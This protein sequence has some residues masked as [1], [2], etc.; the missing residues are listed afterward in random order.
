MLI[1]QTSKY[2]LFPLAL[3]LILCG[4]LRGQADLAILHTLRDT[5]LAAD[6]FPYT[7]SNYLTSSQIIK[8]LVMVKSA[9]PWAPGTVPEIN[10]VIPLRLPN[11]YL[12]QLR[13]AYLGNFLARPEVEATQLYR[14]PLV[15]S[16]VPRHDLTINNIH[17]V[18]AGNPFLNGQNLVLSIKEDRFDPDDIDFKGRQSGSPP[19]DIPI[20][21]HA[22]N[23]ATMAAGGGN[24]AVN[25]KGVAW[26][27]TLLSTPFGD[28]I[29]EP[30]DYYQ[31]LKVSVQNH[32][33]GVGV[34]NFYGLDAAAYDQSVVDKPELVHVFSAGNLGE[35]AS[36]DGPYAGLP[37][38]ANISGSFKMAKNVLVVGAQD[39]TAATALRSS[40][41]PAYDGR[42]KPDLVAYGQD[43][44][45][46][47]AALVSGSAILLQDAWIKKHGDQAS[48]AMIKALLINSADEINQEGPDYKG[49]YGALNLERALKQ[50]K[51]SRCW[52]T[53]LGGTENIWRQE[54]EVTPGCTIW[55]TTLCWID[56]AALPFSHKALVHDLDITIRPAEYPDSLIYY[57][58]IL[59]SAADVQLLSA[60]ARRGP[61]T[62]NNV[63]KITMVNPVPGKYI[64]QVSKRNFNK[65][66]QAFAVV[67]YA[68]KKTNFRWLNPVQG[69]TMTGEEPVRLA[70]ESQLN[71]SGTLE[72]NQNGTWI[73]IE[74]LKEVLGG[75]H[76]WR[77]PSEYSG[78]VRFRMRSEEN[79]FLSDSIFIHPGVNVR[80]GLRCNSLNLVYWNKIPRAF[81]YEIFEPGPVF[82]QK[83][84][85]TEDTLWKK[86]DQ[87]WTYVAVKPVFNTGEGQRSASVK[88]NQSGIGCYIRSFLAD[89]I[90]TTAVLLRLELGT[91]YGIAKIRIS[92]WQGQ[93]F[94]EVK[95][96]PP[97]SLNYWL[98][99]DQLK[100]GRHV[101]RVS[102]LNQDDQELA[103]EITEVYLSGD[104]K[105]HIFPSVLKSGHFITVINKD[106][107][108]G[109]EWRLYTSA[110]Q[111]IHRENNY[112]A[113]MVIYPGYLYPG[114]YIYHLKQGENFSITGKIV[115][116]P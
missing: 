36:P 41:G 13:A 10:K 71:T 37:G 49:G 46:G 114:V 92:Q 89:I 113:I 101:F 8:L 66:Q 81:G 107:L 61:D 64:I 87:S 38:W 82:L 43:G 19:P 6:K 29:P 35:E 74:Q 32:A 115:V 83:T 78:Y 84:A 4:K 95:V 90:N 50:V 100:A 57:P 22:T 51:S 5:P 14:K 98:T 85:F 91:V 56:P 11:Y 47:A 15:E 70:W 111:L 2:I 80:H 30:K 54:F 86:T 52:D 28:L 112:G 20:T 93:V 24:S 27:A 110:G 108:T 55:N 76:Y 53:E 3:V 94:K 21:Q 96:L 12:V 1:E 26:G 58:W 65:V 44:S 45:S 69:I 34:E 103:S 39:T 42:I 79:T 33:Y 62:L 17:L 72:V 68:E 97:D 99:L 23:M 31:N 63:E 48:S 73:F 116:I 102:I 9:A 67:S 25:S 16:M 105:V 106:P 109:V 104:K 59:S 18:H 40:A 88:L 75:Y 77:P 7:L 60:P